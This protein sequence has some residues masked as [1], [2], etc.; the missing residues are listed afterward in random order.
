MSPISS[1]RSSRVRIHTTFNRRPAPSTRSGSSFCRFQDSL[2]FP[3][4]PPGGSSEPARRHR[5]CR[6]RNQAAWDV[7]C[8]IKCYVECYVEC[9]IDCYRNTI[10]LANSSSKFQLPS[11]YRCST[12]LRTTQTWFLGQ[13]PNLSRPVR[14]WKFLSAD[15]MEGSPIE[16]GCC[17]FQFLTIPMGFRKVLTTSG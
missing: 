15:G 1:S 2:E 7:E 12:G 14:I 5:R 4:S 6:A 17:P 3:S 8:Y 16:E 13:H 11:T 9:Y 10:A